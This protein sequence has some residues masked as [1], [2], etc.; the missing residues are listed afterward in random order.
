MPNIPESSQGATNIIGEVTD[1]TE[2]SHQKRTRPKMRKSS[3]DETLPR[4]SKWIRRRSTSSTLCMQ[5]GGEN[6]TPS[7][8]E[9]ESSG[10]DS[11]S[12]L[13]QDKTFSNAGVQTVGV[14][15]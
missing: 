3:T 14:D 6:S 1:L 15:D 11:G 2:S 12:E 13:L 10:H 8:S 5:D 9:F 7:Q 4:S